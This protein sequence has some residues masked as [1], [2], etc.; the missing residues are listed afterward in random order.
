VREL[1]LK[2]DAVPGLQLKIHFTAEKVGD[3]EIAC[4]ELCG[5]GHHRMRSFLQVKEDADY[6]KWLQEQAPSQ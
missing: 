5:L 2:Q 1:R 3:Y 6:Q 4:A